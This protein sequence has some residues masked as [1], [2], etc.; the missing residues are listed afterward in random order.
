MSIRLKVV[1]FLARPLTSLITVPVAIALSMSVLAVTMIGLDRYLVSIDQIIWPV[2]ISADTARV[3]LGAVAAGAITSLSLTYSLVLVVFTLAAG[4]IGPRLLQRFTSDPVNQVTAGLFGGTFIYALT[5]LYFVDDGMVPQITIG[6]AGMMAVIAVMQLIVFV[7]SVAQSIT[8]DAEIAVISSRL[9]RDIE[10]LVE[11]QA[12]GS[13][14]G[15]PD[16]EDMHA[17]NTETA[18]YLGAIDEEKLV[19]LATEHDTFIR[20]AHPAGRFLLKGEPLALIGR[21]PDDELKAIVR[22]CISIDATR[23][24]VRNV[25]FSVHLLVEIAL[26]ALSP[27]TNDTYTAIACI[28]RLAEAL[29]IPVRDGLSHMVRAD[30]DENPRL[31]IRGLSIRMLVGSVLHPL[32][33]ASTDNILMAQRLAGVISS[34]HRIACED[35]ADVLEKHAQM[36]LETLAQSEHLKNDIDSVIEELGPLAKG[37]EK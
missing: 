5:T 21:E 20:L 25:E 30:E 14:D 15:T 34:L 31:H 16:S 18:G 11:E 26:R 7:R 10:Q 13:L 3:F 35:G 22:S 9:T 6:F 36:L 8:I 4:N 19:A 1:S 29:T 12:D 27:G 17:I 37:A 2:V 24:E 23:S 28:E 33:R 32:R